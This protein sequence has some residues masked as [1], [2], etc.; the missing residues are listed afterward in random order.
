MNKD[1]IRSTAVSRWEP[2]GKYYIVQSPL[3]DALIGA[4]D[5][6][7]EAW[8]IFDDFLDDAYTSYLEGRLGGMYGKR[9]RPAK[10]RKALHCEVKPETRK[11]L[12][13]LADELGCSQ[14]ETID[15]LAAF[16]NAAQTAKRGKSVAAMLS[17]DNTRKAAVKAR[18]PKR[19]R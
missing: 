16:F 5:T 17:A 15:Y 18:A 6:E 13:S 19:A 3:Y 7:S 4:A 14:G 11:E 2:K 8:E 12:K 9:G 1:T 10:N